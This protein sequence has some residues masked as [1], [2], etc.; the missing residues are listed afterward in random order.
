MKKLKLEKLYV[1][2]YK[3]FHQA[4][5]K[6]D[7]FNIIVGANNAGK[8][9]FLD[10]LEFIDIAIRQ[11]LIT[12]VKLKGGYDHIR[13]SRSKENFIEIKATFSHT[14]YFAYV[15]KGLMYFSSIKGSRYTFYFRIT[16]GNRCRTKINLSIKANVKRSSSRDEIKQL[17]DDFNLMKFNRIFKKSLPFQFEIHL[18]RE[19]REAFEKTQCVA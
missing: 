14:D 19:A 17:T 18:E 5:F 8:S 10:L 7:D 3:S 15:T 13:N 9:N 16:R 11:D 6:F 12:A 4:T 1:S 2:N